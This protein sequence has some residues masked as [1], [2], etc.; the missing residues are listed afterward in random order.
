MKTLKS[1]STENSDYLRESTIYV[2]NSLTQLKVDKKQV[3]KNEL[4]FEE[5]LVKF[6]Q[7]ARGTKLFHVMISKRLGQV[8]ITLSMFGDEFDFYA[9]EPEAK[10]NDDD[11]FTL[12][13][14]RALLL[15]A[16][17]ENYK[18][19]HKNGVNTI[20]ISNEDSKKSLYAT[21][22]AMALG[23]IVGLI[24]QFALP[25]EVS[26]GVKTYFLSPVKTMFMNAL[27]I[28]I[29]PVVF[30]SIVTCF[31]QYENISQFG[32]LGIKVI[33]M[34]L[35]TTVMAVTLATGLSSIFRPGELGFALQGGA[36]V[37]S[38]NINTDVDT[39]LLGTIVGIVPNNFLAPF[40]ES[41]TL[42]LIFLAVLCGISLGMLGESA[43]SLKELFNNLNSLFVNITG[44]IARLIPLAV[45][46]S[47]SIMVMD[48][49][50]DAF[51]SLLGA[52]VL[53]IG[54]IMCMMMVYGILVLVLGRLN[55]LKFY[56]KAREGMITSFTLSSSSAAMPTNLKV[57]TEKLGISPKVCNF[58]IPLGATINMDGTSILLTNMALFLA[59]A[60]GVNISTSD[61]MSI[62][63]TIVLLSLGAPGVPGSGLVC[64]G[65]VLQAL[66]VPIEAIGLIMPIYPIFDMFNT[67]SNTTG[68]M[69]AS[70]IVA[71]SEN[72]V[73]LKTYNK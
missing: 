14:I 15:K 28:I 29:A 73:D 63:L 25:K 13:A 18:Y 20:R 62:M 21:L 3:I 32:K 11:P 5:T 71:K 48:L 35:I 17:G 36:E 22:I 51:M 1:F 33:S 66:N 45:F 30:F 55:P 46:C 47:L 12:D 31:S 69:A 9:E 19:V 40:V 38:V 60:Y 39:S 52:S 4:L 59:R 27:K 26:A 58:S 67:M 10:E 2:H 7:H 65:I 44:L 6:V 53:H 50:L 43:A 72:L 64:T 57:C 70:L 8:V 54:V 42:Q 68:D 41:N 56:Q 24:L 16:Y 37:A 49:N 34:Y 23:I 61:I